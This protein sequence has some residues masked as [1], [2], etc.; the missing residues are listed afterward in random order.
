MGWFTKD[1]VVIEYGTMFIRANVFFLMANGV[2]HSLAG[3]IRGRGDGRGPMVIMLAT[4]VGV[5]QLYL[6]VVTRWIVNTPLVV[7]LGYPV[8]WVTCMITEMIYYRVKYGIS[9]FGASLRGSS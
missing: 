9:V 7:G 3:A 4:F 5:R 8:G 1:N 6:F 2:N